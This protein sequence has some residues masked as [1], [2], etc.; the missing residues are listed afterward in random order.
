[1][2]KFFLI[3]FFLSQIL[4]VIKPLIEAIHAFATNFIF[5]HFI[6]PISFR[7]FFFSILILKTFFQTSLQFLSLKVNKPREYENLI[8]NF[9]IC[10]RFNEL[11][12]H[13]HESA[14]AHIEPY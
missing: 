8:K 11:F 13:T 6:L 1:M 2:E 7:L 3:N 12:P 9:D 4:K 10:T 14:A 5:V